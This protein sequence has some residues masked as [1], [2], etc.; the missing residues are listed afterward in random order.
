MTYVIKTKNYESQSLIN[1]KLKHETSIT[2]NDLK[3][4]YN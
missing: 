2:Q 3:Q 4:N 1:Q